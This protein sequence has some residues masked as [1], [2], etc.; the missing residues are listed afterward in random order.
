MLDF[1]SFNLNGFYSFQ[2]CIIAKY[3]CKISEKDINSQN[4]IICDLLYNFKSMV[5]ISGDIEKIFTLFMIHS[6]IEDLIWMGARCAKSL[7]SFFN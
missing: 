1:G 6:I 3:F 7:F 4:I 2:S 5:S